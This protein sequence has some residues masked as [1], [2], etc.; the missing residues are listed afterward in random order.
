MKKSR[1]P[2]AFGYAFL[3]FSAIAFTG[4]KNGGEVS[5]V[6]TLATESFFEHANEI[7]NLCGPYWLDGVKNSC[8]VVKKDEIVLYSSFMSFSY[9]NIVWNKVSASE[10]TCTAYRK[11]DSEYK[12]GGK[13]V[14]LTFAVGNDGG[15]T[16]DQYIAA[17][18]GM[19]KSPLKKGGAVQKAGNGFSYDANDAAAPKLR[20]PKAR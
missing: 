19:R 8:T 5:A 6:G 14:V 2:P 9:S 13:K 16:L 18:G 4:F 11:N 17:M 20:A 10:W 15:V 1:L 12:P 3:F 7:E